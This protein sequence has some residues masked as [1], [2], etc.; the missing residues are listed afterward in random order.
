MDYRKVYGGTPKGSQSLC[1]TCLYSRLIKGF[2]ESE[3]ISICDRLYEPFHVPFAVAECTDYV[4]KRLP[5]VE[6]MEKIAWDLTV[7]KSEKKV[8][9]KVVNGSRKFLIEPEED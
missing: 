1:E 3:R 2:A 5:A 8:G 7:A 4:D 9:F 6:E